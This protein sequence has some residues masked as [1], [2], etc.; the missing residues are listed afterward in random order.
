MGLSITVMTVGWILN[1]DEV[2]TIQSFEEWRLFREWREGCR[3]RKVPPRE[4]F[5]VVKKKRDTFFFQN[6][7]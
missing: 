2:N 3:K 6:K 4:I 1:D 5:G 7:K